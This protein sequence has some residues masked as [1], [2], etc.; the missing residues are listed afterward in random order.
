MQVLA[1]ETREIV[2]LELLRQRAL[3]ALEVELPAGLGAGPAAAGDERVGKLLV[4]QQLRRVQALQLAGQG[5][6]AL[7]RGLGDLARQTEL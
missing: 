3:R 4:V 2:D 6:A 7:V 5:L 1:A